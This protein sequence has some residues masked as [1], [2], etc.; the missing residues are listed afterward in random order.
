MK[1]PVVISAEMKRRAVARLATGESATAVA[2]DLKVHRQR[3][4][5]WQD[6]VR[7][8]GLEVLALK[9]QIR[10]LPKRWPNPPVSSVS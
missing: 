4:Y 1:R 10:L 2:A 5:D 8:G 3:L 9:F 6:V 7:Q